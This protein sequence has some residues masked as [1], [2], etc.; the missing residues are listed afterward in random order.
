MGQTTGVLCW[1]A[2]KVGRVAGFLSYLNMNAA[3]LAALNS[4]ERGGCAS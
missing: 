2:C 4:G 3:T 1:L